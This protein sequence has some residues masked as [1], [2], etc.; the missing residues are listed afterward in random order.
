MLF[1]DSQYRKLGFYL[2]RP[3]F[4]VS[5]VLDFKFLFFLVF[6]Q[7]SF[8]N[9]LF[10]FFRLFPPLLRFFSYFQSSVVAYWLQDKML[11]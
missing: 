3:K 10:R 9:I 5:T 2:E 7:L 1:R 11:N 6:L 8:P 4:H